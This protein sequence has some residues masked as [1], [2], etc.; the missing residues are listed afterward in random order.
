MIHPI[1]TTPVSPPDGHGSWLEYALTTLDV[2]SIINQ[3]AL[4]GNRS[5]QREEVLAAAWAE[6][7]A[8]RAQAGLPSVCQSQ[9]QEKSDADPQA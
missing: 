4:D 6:L 9:R 5:I 3:A 2:R 7:N 8:L 1:A